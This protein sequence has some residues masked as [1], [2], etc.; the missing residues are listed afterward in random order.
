MNRVQKLANRKPKIKTR[1]N[2]SRYLNYV[3]FHNLVGLSKIIAEAFGVGE[4][5]KKVKV[6]YEKLIKQFGNELKILMDTT[7]NELKNIA[8]TR[9]IEGIKR[10]R[11]RNLTIKPGYDGQY[12]QI[13]IFNEEDKKFL[14]YGQSCILR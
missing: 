9:V 7:R 8:D 3:P 6:E 14:K 11:E 10:V 5:T 4:N 2:L 13:K 1:N 12:G